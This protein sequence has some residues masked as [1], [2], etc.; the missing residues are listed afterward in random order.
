MSRPNLGILSWSCYC[1]TTWKEGTDASVRNLMTVTCKGCGCK[2]PLIKFQNKMLLG[3]FLKL[4][5]IYPSSD[6]TDFIVS[7]TK[8]DHESL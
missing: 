7:L 3:D 2:N 4:L 1:D 8:A 5:K 6:I